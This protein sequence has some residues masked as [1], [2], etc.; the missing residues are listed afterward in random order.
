VLIENHNLIVEDK[1]IDKRIRQN[2]GV[3]RKSMELIH[4]G[5]A[6]V[7]DSRYL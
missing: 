7:K 2:D 4:F 1:N 6:K 3:K 5:I